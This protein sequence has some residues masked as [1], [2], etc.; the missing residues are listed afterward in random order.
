MSLNSPFAF[1]QFLKRTA[2]MVLVL[3]T[4]PSCTVNILETFGDPTTDEALL[5]DAKELLDAGSYTAALAKFSE[6]TPEFLAEREV[7]I[8]HASAYAGLCGVD[9]LNITEAL[10]SLGA[11]RIFVWLVSTFPGGDAT[12]QANCIL[13]E[14]KI[15]SIGALGTNRTADENFLMAFVGIV[16][17]GVILSRYGDTTP[18]DG[19]ADAGFDPCSG[20]AIPSAD[21]KEIATG[22]NIVVDALSNIGGSTVGSDVVTAVATV[23]ASLPPPYAGL[24]AAPAQVLT[25]DIDATEEQGIRTIIN[26]DQDIGLGSN[27]AGDAAACA[28]P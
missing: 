14:D 6:M 23:C 13:A 16:K 2:A 11:T 21:A 18:A 3:A 27:C 10:A 26:E 24:C 7:K 8:L 5:F 20:A 4:L 1:K 19:T 22:F 9:F 17:M 15:K 25:T 28:C 12:K